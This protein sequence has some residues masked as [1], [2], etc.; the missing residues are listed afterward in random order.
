MF[1]KPIIKSIS[2]PFIVPVS[3]T[4]DSSG[5]AQTAPAMDQHIETQSQPVAH[6]LADGRPCVYEVSTGR[7]PIGDRRVQLHGEGRPIGGNDLMIAAIAIANS[8]VLVTRNVDE[9]SRVSGL[10]MEVW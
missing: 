3:W 4:G 2:D 9:F 6:G 1:H 5:A 7:P 10:E 8:H